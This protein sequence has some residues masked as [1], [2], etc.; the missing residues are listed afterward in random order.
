M[1]PS[2]TANYIQHKGYNLAAGQ[3]LTQF[4]AVKFSAA[5]TVTPV[6]AITDPVCGV[7]QHGVTAAELLKGKGAS[8]AVEG[9][10]LMETN[11][12]IAVGARV[13]VDAVGR[14]ITFTTG[15][16]IIG[17]CIEASAGTGKYARVH[18]ELNG[19]VAGT[20]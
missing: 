2:A 1:P 14:A 12:A 20:A 18:L 7:V 4:R 5:E 15:N 19:D 6:T 9:D 11:G 8:I 13:C 17:R 16:R 3:T 10:T